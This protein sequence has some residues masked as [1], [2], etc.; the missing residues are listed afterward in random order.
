MQLGWRC[1]AGEVAPDSIALP[2]TGVRIKIGS[3]EVFDVD[4][5]AGVYTA[6]LLY[7][8]SMLRPSRLSR[9]DGLPPSHGE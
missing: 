9:Q 6:I 5:A 8:T 3:P 4:E 2:G 7:D 1:T